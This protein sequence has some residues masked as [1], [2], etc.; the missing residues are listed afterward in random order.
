[1]RHTIKKLGVLAM[2][3]MLGACAERLDLAP[4]SSVGE[5]NFWQTGDQVEAFVSGLHSRFRSHVQRF[6]YL[7]EMRAD[8]H[9]TDPGTNSAFTGESTAGN[10]RLWQN[11]L[12]LDAP[13]VAG[14]GGFY[15]NINQLNLLISK[16]KTSTVVTTANRG[17]VG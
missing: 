5:G 6:L 17:P 1:M 9:G 14:Y 4:I 12:N 7:G 10:E 11:T 15:S 2:V 13:G 16:V 3:L 8:I